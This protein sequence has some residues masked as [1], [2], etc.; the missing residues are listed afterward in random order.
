M[1]RGSRWP[2]LFLLLA[3]A[4]LRPA[5]SPPQNQSG[6]SQSQ[7]SKGSQPFKVSSLSKSQQRNLHKD[8]QKYGNGRFQVKGD[9][10]VYQ[11]KNGQKPL[12]IQG[13]RLA[14]GKA[15]TKD[16]FKGLQKHLQMRKEI[17][18]Y[19]QSR[20]Q[21]R[22]SGGARSGA[23]Q[24]RGEQL[25]RMIA[26]DPKSLSLERDVSRKEAEGFA[27]MITRDSIPSGKLKAQR[28]GVRARFGSG[29]RSA[30]EAAREAR[31]AP[32]AAAPRGMSRIRDLPSPRSRFGAS[33]VRNFSS[34]SSRGGNC[35]GVN[36]LARYDYASS[37][38]KR[39]GTVTVG[40]AASRVLEWNRRATRD[41]TAAQ[42]PPDPPAAVRLPDG[43]KLAW[44]DSRM[45]RAVASMVQL[46][47]SNN[48]RN[49]TYFRNEQSLLSQ[50]RTNPFGTPLSLSTR[51]GSHAVTGFYNRS[52]GK[53]EIFDPNS[54]R[55]G[56]V[57]ATLGRGRDG[58]LNLSYYYPAGKGY[59]LREWSG[60][61]L[62]ALQ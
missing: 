58:R 5:E 59:R 54:A 32:R 56:T 27:R 31:R 7:N 60:I 48:N 35:F 47:P 52:T 55:G 57:S 19:L 10:V 6:Q 49:R 25:R 33:T 41:R 28:E 36:L 62:S 2:L 29:H 42:P 13:R 26:N 38:A 11:G 4:P 3:A 61:S 53:I 23:T 51:R 1:V 45:Q 17:D 20:Q 22:G 14:E 9:K 43:R 8:L 40:Q 15:L 37:G 34:K 21:A 12:T 24:A 30:W 44:G 50:L 18:G 16:Q 39:S 46:S